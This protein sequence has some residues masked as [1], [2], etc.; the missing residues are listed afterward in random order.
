M[1]NPEG[2]P[3]ALVVWLD[4]GFPKANNFVSVEFVL[5]EPANGFWLLLWKGEE[6]EVLENNELLGFAA[7]NGEATELF[8]KGEENAEVD[9]CV[10]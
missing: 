2:L 7:A 5:L 3:N 4:E 9:G 8:P 1:P 6:V 10:P